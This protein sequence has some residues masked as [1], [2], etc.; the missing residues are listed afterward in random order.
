MEREEA[1]EKKDEGLTTL[2]KIKER[3]EAV[4]KKEEEREEAVE[5]KEEGHRAPGKLAERDEEAEDIIEAF[6]NIYGDICE[7]FPGTSEE[8]APLKKKPNKEKISEEVLVAPTPPRRR[9]TLETAWT[10]LHPS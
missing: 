3:E 2:G 5:K 4:E 10:K 7:H 6:C 8:Q 1:A 9:E